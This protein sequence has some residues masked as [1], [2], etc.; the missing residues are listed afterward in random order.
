MTQYLKGDSLVLNDTTLPI[1][2]V[3]GEIRFS[4]ADQTIRKFSAALSAWTLVGGG[5][6]GS[7]VSWYGRSGVAPLL[8]EDLG[9]AVYKFGANTGNVLSSMIK[10]PDGYQAGSEIKLLIGYYS[11]ANTDSVTWT[12]TSNLIRPDFQAMDSTTYQKISGAVTPNIGP[13]NVVRHISL[14]LT[15]PDGTVSGQAVNAGDFLKVDL[16]RSGTD[17]EEVRF[18]MDATEVKF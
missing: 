10:V 2:G 6:G 4:S 13:V 1:S 15:E 8:T 12:T 7:S 17:T 11:P 16:T 18:L 9:M 5:A 3:D 14:T